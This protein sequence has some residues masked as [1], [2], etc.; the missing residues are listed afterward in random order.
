[1]V[2]CEWS[3]SLLLLSPTI[4]NTG[5]LPY[6]FVAGDNTLRRHNQIMSLCGF[7]TLR[8]IKM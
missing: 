3:M 8:E 7:A 5:K 6:H 2:N 4:Q 1:M